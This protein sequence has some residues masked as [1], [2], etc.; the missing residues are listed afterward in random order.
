MCVCVFPKVTSALRMVLVL[1]FSLCLLP[2]HG[3]FVYLSPTALC[4]PE[5]QFHSYA[6]TNDSVRVPLQTPWV[7]VPCVPNFPEQSLPLPNLSTLWDSEQSPLGR[8]KR[9]VRAWLPCPSHTGSVVKQSCEKLIL[10]D[11]GKSDQVELPEELSWGPLG[12]RHLRAGGC[13]RGLTNHP[14]LL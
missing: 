3:V 13:Q 9:R 14:V 5:K 6:S 2:W 8:R 10:S 7:C 11:H 1:R 4:G 12:T